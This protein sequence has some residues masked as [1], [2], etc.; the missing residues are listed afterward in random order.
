MMSYLNTDSILNKVDPR[1]KIII[2]SLL[3]VA[4]FFVHNLL[5]LGI[6]LLLVVALT[7]LAKIPLLYCIKKLKSP[8]IMT[9]IMLA[10]QMLII[11]HENVFMYGLLITVRLIIVI[12]GVFILTSTTMQWEFI[13]SLESFLKPAQKI[14]LKTGS[15]ML[16][17]RIIGRFVPSITHEANKILKAQAARGLDI[18][19]ANIWMKMRLIGALLLPVFIVAIQRADDLSY[20]MA[21]R[22]YAVNQNRSSYQT[23]QRAR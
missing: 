15:I 12:I 22:G 10:L 20:S 11:S 5:L 8:V 6:F 23:L 2:C 19:G 21:V 1:L 17:F 4:I 18:K 14:G 7:M 9:I 13:L 3:V 16:S